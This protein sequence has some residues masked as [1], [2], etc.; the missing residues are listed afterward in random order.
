LT[1]DAQRHRDEQA[2]HQDDS[3]LRR[4]EEANALLQKLEK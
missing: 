2:T 4:D 3:L 1:G